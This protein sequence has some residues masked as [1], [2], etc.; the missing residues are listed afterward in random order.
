MH[1]ATEQYKFMTKNESAS[2]N[3]TCE[4][5]Y[6]P[7]DAKPLIFSTP[8]IE[9]MTINTL[10]QTSGFLN[11]YPEIRD[12]PVGVFGKIANL[13]TLVKRGDRVELYRQLLA[14]PK[15]KRRKQALSKLPKK[16]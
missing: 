7:S 10:L 15:E 8:W 12:F 1:L 13:L 6:I 3:D 11:H 9:G 2:R 14:D 16:S 4:L 5:V